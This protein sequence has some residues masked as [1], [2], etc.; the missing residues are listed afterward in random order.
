M[1]FQNRKRTANLGAGIGLP[2]E[3]FGVKGLWGLL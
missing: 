3:I 2:L 1:Y